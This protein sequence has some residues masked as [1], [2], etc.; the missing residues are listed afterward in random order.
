MS[1]RKGL[2]KMRFIGKPDGVLMK[3]APGNYEQGSVHMK[4]IG[5]AK[6][7]FWEPLEKL[8]E[9]V[10]PPLTVEDDAYMFI[11]EEVPELTMSGSDLS[12]EAISRVDPNAPAILEP[13]LSFNTGTGKLSEIKPEDFTQTPEPEPVM[14]TTPFNVLPVEEEKELSRDELLAV[15]KEAGV[16]VKPRTRTTTLL[17]MVDELDSKEES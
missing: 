7:K 5:K 14:L 1:K 3:N 9:I 10:A 13:H 6:L 16:P 15:L 8:P 17:K 2:V 4:S 11:P 12:D